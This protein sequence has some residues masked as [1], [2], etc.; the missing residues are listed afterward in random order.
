MVPKP[1]VAAAQAV[2]AHALASLR[3][4]ELAWEGQTLVG[5][6]TGRVREIKQLSAWAMN[7]SSMACATW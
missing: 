1:Q 4:W 2:E 7:S 5:A 6:V 3:P